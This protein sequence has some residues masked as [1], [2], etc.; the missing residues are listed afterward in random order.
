MAETAAVETRAPWRPALLVDNR[1]FESDAAVGQA[2]RRSWSHLQRTAH[3]GG[4][5]M[6]IVCVTSCRQHCSDLCTVTSQRTCERPQKCPKAQPVEQR[7]QLLFSD[8]QC[9]RA[10]TPNSRAV[11]AKADATNS[12]C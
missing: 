5:G 10:L 2:R 7:G 9:F 11:V 1:R 12:S 8:H 4:L 6:G 3:T